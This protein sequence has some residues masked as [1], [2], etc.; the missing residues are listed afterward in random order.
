VLGSL[1]RR[2]RAATRTGQ[3]REAAFGARLVDSLPGLRRYAIA[4]AGE[5]SLADDLVQSCCERAWERRHALQDPA[6][7]GAWLRAILTNLHTDEM[8]RRKRQPGEP[9]EEAA[10]D[11]DPAL[12]RRASAGEA[13]DMQ[14]ALRRLSDDHR[15][16]LLLV[17]VEQL[18]YAEAAD[19]LEVPVGTVMS[20]LARARAALRLALD[21]EAL[22]GGAQPAASAS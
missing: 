8:R 4:L 22:P 17:G 12:S 19:A 20:R 18:S 2:D 7:L 21:G 16:V 11:T 1:S 6:R 9:L 14:R 13:L 15:A 5:V 10:L 3:T